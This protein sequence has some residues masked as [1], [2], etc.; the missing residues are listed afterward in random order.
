MARM[1]RG[2]QHQDPRWM[3]ASLGHRSGRRAPIIAVNLG[4][5]PFSCLALL[6]DGWVNP[7]ADMILYVAEIPAICFRG[8]TSRQLGM[9]KENADLSTLMSRLAPCRGCMAAHSRRP[10][11]SCILMIMACFHLNDSNISL[12]VNIVT[13]QTLMN[14]RVGDRSS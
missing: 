12:R 1:G 6:Y 4:I 3:V 5:S 8:L 13:A 7:F 11:C 9:S 14:N 10:L 2:F